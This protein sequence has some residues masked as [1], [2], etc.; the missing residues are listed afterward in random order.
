MFGALDDYREA[1]FFQTHT[2]GSLI[3][4]T[5]IYKL[6]IFA[7]L[8]A[9]ATEEY[10][11]APTEYD[12]ETLPFVLENAIHTNSQNLP[13]GRRMFALSTCKYPDTTARTIV[14]TSVSDLPVDHVRTTSSVEEPEE[15]N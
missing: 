8:E 12:D 11:F 15:S 13:A 14:M 4:G 7:V 1:D 2:T 10:I 5:D 6:D 3:V 9:D